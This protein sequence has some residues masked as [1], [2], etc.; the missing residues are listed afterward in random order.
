MNR[1]K[2]TINYYYNLNINTIHQKEKNYYFKAD[3][4][5]YLLLKCTNIEEPDDIYRLNIYLSQILPVNRIVL[6]VNN[7]VITKINDSNYLLLELFSNNN[8]INLNNIIELSNIRIPFSVD[9]LRR[10]DWYNLWIKKIDYFEYQLSQ[11]G[12]KYPLIRE[13]FNYYIGLAENAI[14]LVNNIDFN[15]IPLG[16]SHRRITNMSFNL[17]NPLNIVIDARIR[18]VCEYFKFCFFNNIDISMELELFLSYNS[19]NI[20]EAKLFLARMFFPTYYFDLYEKIIDN[21]I[22][23]SEIKKVII[24]A[25]N[26]E[27]ILKQVYYHFKNNQINIEW[28]EI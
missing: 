13:S 12:K 7:E 27:K 17:Y 10:N 16:L 11:I 8:K 14:I 24:K 25:D 2:N 28:L 5:N 15:N 19:F 26:Y 20:D 18:D 22:D 6:N 23:E 9:K 21:E 1:L 4:K 3:N